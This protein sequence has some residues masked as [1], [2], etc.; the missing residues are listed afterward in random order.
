MMYKS[1]NNN[2][3]PGVVDSCQ[4][5]IMGSLSAKRAAIMIITIKT[6]EYKFNDF[7]DHSNTESWSFAPPTIIGAEGD[8]IL[9]LSKI[10]TYQK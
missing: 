7:L 6:V 4:R 8:A 5:A 2:S 9:L 10:S 3:L 1:N